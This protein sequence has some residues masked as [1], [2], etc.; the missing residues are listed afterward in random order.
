MTTPGPLKNVGVDANVGTNNGER[1]VYR[2]DWVFAKRDASNLTQAQINAAIIEGFDPYATKAFVNAADLKNANAD[3]VLNGSATDLAGDIRRID[4]DTRNANGGVPGLDANGKIDIAR[5]PASAQVQFWPKTVYTPATYPASL[6][7]VTG[8]T[9]TTLIT[10]TIPNPGYD[11]KILVSGHFDTRTAADGQ[12]PII[13]TRIGSTAGPIIAQ[14]IGRDVQSRYGVD[15]FG[16]ISFSLGSGWEQVY[17]GIGD[18][19]AAT[20]GDSLYWY[21]PVTGYQ[22]PPP[23]GPGTPQINA[24]R[25][26]FFRK[27]TDFATTID[28]YQQVSV[29]ITE[30]GGG[31]GAPWGVPAVNRIYGRIS[32]DRKNYVAFEW[33]AAGT[34]SLLYAINGVEHPMVGDQGGFTLA[35]NDEVVAQF[36]YYASTNKRRFRLLR[37]GTAKID[38]TESAGDSL[39]GGAYR[40]WGFGLRQGLWNTLVPND[41]APPATFDWIAL[42]DPVAPWAA[43]PE[44]Y[45]PV[46]LTPTALASQ[47]VFPG[48]AGVTSTTTLVTT[49][50]SSGTGTVYVSG[51]NTAAAPPRMYVTV[52]PAAA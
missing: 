18:N 25:R 33:D 29:K 15:D 37:N 28:D 31:G 26:G 8:T 17:T 50:R 6:G 9:E 43:D 1:T 46:V 10:H 47:A 16:R 27:I 11:Y 22:L 5:V 4:K 7:T 30:P 3:Y 19:I 40:G 21:Q 34:C 39:M 36:G 49:L 51:T 32:S 2:R 13:R 14:G 48:G 24:E 12:A 23:L 52:I 45:S 38:W 35:A 41:A 44:C 20:D 42:T